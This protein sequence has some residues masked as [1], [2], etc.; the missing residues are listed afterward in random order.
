LDIAEACNHVFMGTTYT[1]ETR[2]AF[3]LRP[4]IK[5][6]Y[7]HDADERIVGTEH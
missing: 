6:I 4:M 7:R 1:T 3:L 2:K 5:S